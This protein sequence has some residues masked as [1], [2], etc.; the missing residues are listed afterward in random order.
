MY[1]LL[2]A[3]LI[4]MSGFLVYKG[5]QKKKTGQIVL[6]VILA[7]FTVFF[8]WFM[9]FWG[10]ML[11]FEALGYN[12]RFW[13]VVFSQTAIAAA[14]IFFGGLFVWPL[15]RSISKDK[16]WVKQG[17]RILGAFIGAVWAV[18]NW[19]VV[20]RFWF[21]VGSEVKD[22]ILGKSTS[23]YLFSL[24]FLD[25]LYMLVLL[26]SLVS[27][28]A[29]FAASFLR[30]E[31]SEM[32]VQFF[33][34]ESGIS[35][36]MEKNLFLNAAV[37]LI[38]L[39]C[40]KYLSRFHLLYSDWG[41]VTGA[42]WTDV[43]IRLPGYAVAV[44]LT[45]LLGVGILI[46][47][48]RNRIGRT[49]FGKQYS[50]PKAPVYAL[51]ALGI[52]TLAVWFLVLTI[53]P[54]LFQWLRV[55]PN[56]ITFEKPYIENNIQLTQMGFAL[57][58]IQEREYPA[59][60]QFTPEI[61]E[62]NQSIF[63]N[64]RLWDWRALDAV[65][66]QF[67]EIR[68]Y[69]EFKDVD[70]DRYTFA[71]QYRQVM[72]SAR[73][74][75][76]TNLPLQSQTFVNKRFKYT[77]GNGIT[78]TTVNEFTPDGL[79]NLLVKD[80]PPQSQH[81]EL[82]VKLP[83]IYYGELSSNYVVANSR[84]QEFDYPSGE[85]NVYTHYQGTGG[86]E[87][88]NGWRK[89][90]FGWKFDGT[91]FFLSGYPTSKSRILFHRQI[92]ERIQTLAPFLHF[93]DD[94]YVVLAEGKLYWII[95]AYTS[96]SYYPY[97]EPFS[98]LEIIDYKRGNMTQS[99]STQVAPQLNGVNYLRNA[100]KVVVDAYNGSVDFYIFDPE[101]PIIRVWNRIF[102]DMFKDK[103]E[104]PDSL[105]PH[106]RYPSD[107]LL[108]QGRVYSKYHMTDPTVF[109]NQEDLWIRATEKYYDQV[110]PVEPY[111]VMWEL[112]DEDQP[113]FVLILPFTP[114]NRQVLIGWIAGM[115]DPENYGRFL[116]YKFPKE[117][118]MLGPQQVETKI[119]QD[120]FLSG[121]L[122]LW[123]QRGSN[124]IRGNVLAI[125]VGKT[126]IYV[127]PIYLQAETA[128]Y[129]ELRL[130]AVMHKDTLSYAETFDKALQGLFDKSISEQVILQKS[131]AGET[132]S[133]GRLIQDADAAFN[134]YLR[135]LGEKRF[136]EAS[137]A[138]ARLQ[139]ALSQL[140]E[141]SGNQQ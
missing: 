119:D 16:T 115:C 137:A 30:F 84:E 43:H 29:V 3:V 24:P 74:L 55:E 109:Y 62:N 133:I 110:Q 80:I 101:D 45:L 97:S 65:Y 81:P 38:I 124:V 120:R 54:G 51:A 11:W 86:V 48:V 90:L 35:K 104:I 28:G 5:A 67:Q 26:L 27:L 99:L 96:S 56:E 94:P 76:L 100:V 52:V 59:A 92:N 126:L 15:T 79:P 82:E 134:D 13:M 61:V 108:V 98:S 58:R 85:Q 87:I 77:H 117:K 123:D 95:D 131:P 103:S 66:K 138:L 17:A 20:L 121:Q 116:A 140:M 112:P 127:E 93:D 139:Q 60:E 132:Q 129:P 107:M 83:Q 32:D 18:S 91:K 71:D 19:E 42:G 40:G 128:A 8:F 135:L 1:T 78:L 111:Y 39:A 14:G 89:F 69:Y 53:I 64:I 50:Y 118:R 25:R 2:L 22:P 33:R 122:S 7:L 41:A 4:G 102:P 106:V 75:E 10:E 34:M 44:A 23:F 46:P 6:G 114:K 37:V 141:R 9:Y 72:V 21:Q 12:Q 47:S 57:D 113:Q 36:N 130:V 105:L 136:Q 70:I 31:Q 49:I 73:E 88:S 63:R 125:P 68:L